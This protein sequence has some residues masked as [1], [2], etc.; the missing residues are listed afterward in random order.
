MNT[1]SQ[2][3]GNIILLC[4]FLALGIG[5]IGIWFLY[6]SSNCSTN[7][8]DCAKDVVYAKTA[9]NVSVEIFKVLRSS[10]NINTTKAQDIM[11]RCP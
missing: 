8:N 5:T 4:G 2:N 1:N 11:N 3:N 7:N 9:I 6:K 10:L